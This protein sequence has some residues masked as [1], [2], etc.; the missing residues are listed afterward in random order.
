MHRILEVVTPSPE[1]LEQSVAHLL[2]V[3]LIRRGE[4]TEG[5]E[6]AF[7]HALTQESVY[8][9]I[10]PRARRD[11]HLRV[12]AAIEERCAHRLNE[13][14]GMLAFHYSCAEDYA[15]AEDYL[16]KAG[17]EAAR[18][19]A[20]TE[21]IHYF[22]QALDL[23]LRRPGVDPDR[24]GH[25][26]R[27][28]GLA[29]Y[30][31]GQMVQAV[32][33]FDRALAHW[34]AKRPTTRA[35][36]VG[37]LA[38]DAASLFA[39]LYLR[40]RQ[41]SRVPNAR[42]NDIIHL[43]FRKGTA[44]VSLDSRRYFAESLGILRRINRF[45]ITKVPQGAA[46][47][48]TASSLFAIPAIS[49]AV[50]R[51]ILEYTRPF[52]DTAD[53]KVL[54]YHRFPELMHDYLSGNWMAAAP[55][56]PALVEANAKGG[57]EWFLSVYIVVSAAIQ[58]E[59]GR[60][61]SAAALLDRLGALGEAFE[62]DLIR[63]RRHLSMTRLLMKQRRL[64]LAAAEAERGVPL[65]QQIDHPMLLL[66]MYGLKANVDLHRGDRSALDQTL[67]E[68]AAVHKRL[69]RVP[70]YYV[71]SY[72]V[73]QL[74]THLLDLETAQLQGDTRAG[75]C[76]DAAKRLGRDCLAAA[77]M[78][79]SDLPEVWR[80]LGVSEW[81]AG[82]KAAAFTAWDRSRLEAERMGARPELARTYAEVARRLSA[83]TESERWNGLDAGALDARA[84]ECLAESV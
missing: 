30:H 26:E 12:A 53:P 35:G 61:S 65:L 77:R 67:R 73:A 47:Y 59:Q 1:V 11:L 31:K 63:A 2:R 71:T 22:K 9:M 7:S 82:G 39:R 4:G 76:R 74:G 68:A 17:S 16:T 44:I 81:L 6:Y 70:P 51:R 57:E 58:T 54:L 60:Y 64:E 50:S 48:A 75:V 21:A 15:K 52:I 56:D 32:E 33:H 79:A 23:Y 83:G 62:N 28:I 27:H 38:L 45:D 20:S 3:Q 29:F 10:V 19:A 40:T 24:T 14:Y 72:L 5:V 37:V 66:Y 36:T 46:I 84:R 18:A 13:F 42:D 55:Y 80:L 25:L 8:S 34:R 49:F 43:M 69:G 41:P 78:N